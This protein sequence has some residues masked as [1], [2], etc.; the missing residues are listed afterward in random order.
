MAQICLSS[1]NSPPSL[2][3][4][5]PLLFHHTPASA[6]LKSP[7]NEGGGLAG[8]VW[9]EDEDDLPSV[10]P[11]LAGWLA[12]LLVPTLQRPAFQILASSQISD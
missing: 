4:S 10:V 8:A 1:G 6:E 12:G 3:P 11:G 7:D 2:P 5:L 9:A